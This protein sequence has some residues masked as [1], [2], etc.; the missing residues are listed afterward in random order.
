[1]EFRFFKWWIGIYLYPEPDEEDPE[2][3]E[4]W[5]LSFYIYEIH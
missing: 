1:M 2:N 3:F 5:K 4:V